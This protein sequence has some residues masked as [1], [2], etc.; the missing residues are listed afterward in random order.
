MD[1]RMHSSKR[2]FPA[3]AALAGAALLLWGASASSANYLEEFDDGQAQSWTLG[4][5]WS[6]QGT[7]A[8]GLYLG[9]PVTTSSTY[10][11]YSGATWNTGYAYT[12]RMRT[13]GPANARVG[14]VFNHQNASNFYEVTVNE[15]GNVSLNRMLN[16][17]RTDGIKTATFVTPFGAL[18]QNRFYDL[19]VLR[20]GSEVTVRI[21]GLVALTH[22]LAAGQV[23]DGRIGVVSLN[24][25]GQF[26]FTV[27]TSAVAPSGPSFPR[28]GTV[29]IGTTNYDEPAVQAELA[30]TDVALIPYSTL[31]NIDLGA[32][33]NQIHA[34]NANTKVIVYTKMQEA[35]FDNTG[36]ER[37]EPAVHAKIVEHDW[38]VR[39]TAG[40]PLSATY[41]PAI[42][43]Q[44]NITRN[45]L[46]PRDNGLTYA[47]WFAQWV[48]QNYYVPNDSIDGIYM[49]NAG[50][51]LL[52]G[53]PVDP[54]GAGD[55]NL[56]GVADPGSRA[57]VRQWYR[58]GF[59]DFFDEMGAGMPSNKF[60]F[61]NTA[62]WGQTTAADNA[63]I[64]EY[65]GAVH[66]G[67]IENLIDASK[68]FAVE[69]WGG[70][71]RMMETYR[72]VLSTLA[73]SRQ[74]GLFMHG[75][76]SATSYQEMRYGLASCLLDDGYYTPYVTPSGYSTTPWFDEF[77]VNLGQAISPPPTAAWQNGVW[78]RDYQNGIALANPKANGVK[79]VT[80]EPGFSR[81]DG[82]Q[83]P[84]VNNGLP[85][86]SITLQE[87]DGIILLRD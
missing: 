76:P 85:A 81:I 15:A 53:T 31:W 82:D 61:A 5:G 38:W 44:V 70:W 21:N 55:W 47:R 48:A 40:V 9:G 62:T 56:D 46:V 73:G 41:K 50:W 10:S 65:Y 1:S 11:T 42:F 69:S 43:K 19:Q 34:L 72:K 39:N 28:I 87:R 84:G 80:V 17:T 74:L 67:V 49:D 64:A 22:T 7:A 3:H 52:P 37:T 13:T 30:K 2:H 18:S 77:D 60:K 66:G 71:L 16:G 24:D 63:E 33:A 58:R 32:A 6:V 51:D 23:F 8:N 83:A 68:S 14:A 26:D 78:R 59:R 27:V 75:L 45:P 35:N 86:S 12:V 25:T 36:T 4:S 54:A 57:D 79:T 20:L 29:R